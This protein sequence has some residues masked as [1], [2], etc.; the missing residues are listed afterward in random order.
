MTKTM[1]SEPMLWLDDHRGIYIPRDFALS[2]ADRAKSVTGVSAEDW[3][4]LERGPDGGMDSDI[5]EDES[6]EWYWDTWTDVCDNARVTDDNGV[7][8]FVYQDGACW[9]IPEG[10]EWSDSDEF[11]IWPDDSEGDS[12]DDSEDDSEVDEFDSARGY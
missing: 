12:E 3:T 10:M 8:Y 11:F 7:V 4:I 9:L 5:P 1:Q 6:N 2:F